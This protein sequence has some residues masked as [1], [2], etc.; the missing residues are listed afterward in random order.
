M[1]KTGGL[2]ELCLSWKEWMGSFF[3]SGQRT[4]A[5]GTCNKTKAES[6]GQRWWENRG[7]DRACGSSLLIPLFSQGSGK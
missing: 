3:T 5:R 6:V 2:V 1:N 4:F 7:G